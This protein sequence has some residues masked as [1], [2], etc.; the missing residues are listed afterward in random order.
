MKRIFLLLA[1]VIGMEVYAGDY[2]YL[3]FETSTGAKTSVPVTGLSITYSGTKLYAGSVS[4]EV[5]DLSKMYFSS[6][7]LS[8]GVEQLS[9]DDLDEQSVIYD[10]Y[11]RR[12]T[13]DQLKNGV[14]LVK[15]NNAT[16][17]I[18]VK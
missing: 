5:P 16:Y 10:L 6:T 8:A 15:G 4:F 2:A 18:M 1:A 17:K 3:T 7:D 13:K 9:L 14:Y 11:G 12:L